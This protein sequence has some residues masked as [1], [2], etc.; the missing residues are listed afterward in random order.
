ML[1]FQENAYKSRKLAN[2]YEAKKY[3][4]AKLFS[5]FVSFMRTQRNRL[6]TS[7]KTMR[8]SSNKQNAAPTK[9]TVVDDS[10]LSLALVFCL[11]LNDMLLVGTVNSFLI[12]TAASFIFSCFLLAVTAGVFFISMQL[13]PFCSLDSSKTAVGRAAGVAAGDDTGAATEGTSL[14]PEGTDV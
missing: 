14:P 13:Q 1:S 11:V 2:I 12:T 3:Q 8:H 10:R 5:R 9:P 6:H 7:P 4:R